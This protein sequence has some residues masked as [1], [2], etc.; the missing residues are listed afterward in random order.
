MM[1]FG[2]KYPDP[3]RMVSMGDFSKELCGGT[4]LANTGDVGVMEIKSDSGLSAGTRRIEVFTGTKAE[5]RRQ[6][7]IAEANRCAE[8]LGCSVD[9]LPQQTRELF[10]HVK[11][12]KKHLDSGKSDIPRREKKNQGES[13]ELEYEQIRSRLKQAALA[14]NSDLF[15]TAMRIEN[16]IKEIS[17]LEDQI[18][19]LESSGGVSVDDLI[20]RATESQG[21]KVIAAEI[22]GGNPNLLRSTIDQIRKKTSPVAVLLAAVTGESKVLLVAGI[23]KE[24]VEQGA[25][26][27]NWIKKVAPVVG[28]GGGGKP[29]MAQA[30]GKD[31]S[32]ISEAL[33]FAVSNFN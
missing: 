20:G 27:G 30:G 15:D 13:N 7:I 16:A 25:S 19:Q 5:E 24:L 17:K 1:L 2:E 31:P 29:D 23:S 8:L 28:G 3:C 11:L 22:P 21:V 33:E 18:S 4:H 26:A 32:K 10:D 14:S 12:L 6:K 9:E